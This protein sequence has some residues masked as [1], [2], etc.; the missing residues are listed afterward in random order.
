[1]KRKI[2]DQVVK[3]QKPIYRKTAPGTLI[4]RHPISARL[5]Q[6]MEMEA[7][8]EELGS[9]LDQFELIKA[10]TGIYADTFTLSEIESEELEE[11][12]TLDHQGRGKFNV[13]GPDG[14]IINENLLSKDEAENLKQQ[15][16]AE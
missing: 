2:K 4:L 16:E 5:K 3:D 6:K 13:V 8:E 1:M 7:T 15:L 10:G 11:R 9:F 14:K 12:Y